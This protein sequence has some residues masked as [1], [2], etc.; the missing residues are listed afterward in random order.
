MEELKMR[1]KRPPAEPPN[2]EAGSP[3]SDASTESSSRE[4]ESCMEEESSLEEESDEEESNEEENE[5]EMCSEP[6][7]LSHSVGTKRIRVTMSEA[8]EELDATQPTSSHD[9]DDDFDDPYL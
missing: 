7:S 6:S 2:S 1:L 5:E 8:E 3:G 9:A 4:E